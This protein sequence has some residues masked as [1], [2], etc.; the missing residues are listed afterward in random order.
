MGRYIF[1]SFWWLFILVSTLIIVS[2][3]SGTSNPGNIRVAGAWDVL[4]PFQRKILTNTQYP[5]TIQTIF[6][7]SAIDGVRNGYYDIAILGREPSED[8]LINLQD[9]VVAYDAVC[10]IVDANSFEG[11]EY[12]AGTDNPIRRSAGFSSLTVD[13]LKQIFSYYILPFGHR[14]YWQKDYYTYQ[15]TVDLDTLDLAPEKTWIADTRVII[16]LLKLT[17]GKYDTQTLL[18]ERLGLDE[19]EM[20]NAWNHVYSNT[21]LTAEEEILSVEYR[22]GSPYDPGTSDFQFKIEFASRRVIPIAMQHIPIQVVSI[23]SINPMTD[24]TSVYSGS[25]PFSRKIHLV[26]R[27]NPS[28]DVDSIISSL[29]TPEGQDLLENIGFLPLPKE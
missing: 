8:E 19:A 28:S 4:S 26:T 13:D 7:D 6:S 24:I 29:L 12:P 3:C 20:A 25:Y 5:D 14:W 21:N 11:G 15:Q 27:Q 10:I 17:P 9:T 2:S 16:P 18:Y 22:H 1:K 23:N